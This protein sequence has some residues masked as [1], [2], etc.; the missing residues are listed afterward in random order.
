MPS[1]KPTAIVR[2]SVSTQAIGKVEP[3]RMPADSPSGWVSIIKAF[4]PLGP[5]AQAYA[6]TLAYRLESKRLALEEVRIQREASLARDKIDRAFVLEME[7]LAQ[8]RLVLNKLF[9]SIDKQISNRHLERQAI[10]DMARIAMQKALEPGLSI[11]ERQNAKD[12]ATTLTSQV[13]LFGESDN[14]SLRRL[15]QALP[16]VQP[17]CA[18]L[19]P[20]DE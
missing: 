9:E 8:R 20:S 16:T 13:V 17:A 6:E 3:A 7:K 1:K 18:L 10:L 19:P 2:T 4:N 11:E 14:Q 15:I 5:I 12:L